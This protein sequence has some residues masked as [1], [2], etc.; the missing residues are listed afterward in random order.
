MQAEDDMPDPSNFAAVEGLA[1][2]VAIEGAVAWLEPEQT[3]SC[4]GC[5]SSSACGA[6]VFGS[7]LHARRFP[8]DN[9]HELK[10]GDR[11]VIGVQ[12]STLVKASMTAYAIPLVTMLCSGTVAHLLGHE[13]GITMLATFAGLGIGL[14]IARLRAKKLTAQGELT[15]IYLR[16]APSPAQ[17]ESCQLN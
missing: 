13:D 2:V 3:S 17:S 11:V 7:R 8:L 15:P 6:D 10:V 16:H 1:K 12:E 5:A 14:Y 4:G 9:V